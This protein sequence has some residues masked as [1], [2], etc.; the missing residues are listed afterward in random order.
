MPYYISEKP[1]NQRIW[2][3]VNNV[4]SDESWSQVVVDK[5]DSEWDDFLE[6]CRQQSHSGVM[7]ATESEVNQA[8]AMDITEMPTTKK[9]K[10]KRW[11]K[12]V[13]SIQRH[14]RT[15]TNA[16][17]W[18]DLIGVEIQSIDDPILQVYNN[19]GKKSVPR[20]LVLH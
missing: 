2:D 17:K 15:A 12:N 8:I 18:A 3:K 11:E 13:Q 20:W 16:Q 5:S 4:V 14:R 10:P 7:F 19:Q 1:I 9:K 6:K